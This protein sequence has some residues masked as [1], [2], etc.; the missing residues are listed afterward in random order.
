MKS[1]IC[2]VAICAC[3]FCGN[4]QAQECQSGFCQM[5]VRSAVAAVMQPVANV[6]KQVVY[7][8]KEVAQVPAAVVQRATV[9][10]KRVAARAR[11]FGSRLRC[12]FSR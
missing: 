7:A 3:L 4:V 8:A 1:F 6:G 11:G 10:T 9:T 2:V 5:P 12:A